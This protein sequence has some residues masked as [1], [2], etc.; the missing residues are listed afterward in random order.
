MTEDEDYAHGLETTL[1]TAISVAMETL[2]SMM[3][4][5]PAEA[6]GPQ[7]GYMRAVTHDAR[8]ELDLFLDDRDMARITKVNT[9]IIEASA[10]LRTMR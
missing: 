3:A 4:Q 6:G 10:F 1:F 5:V 8:R 7:L 9:M 2:E